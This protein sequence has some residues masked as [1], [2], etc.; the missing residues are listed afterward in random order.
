MKPKKR[1]NGGFA[2]LVSLVGVFTG[3]VS[4]LFCIQHIQRLGCGCILPLMGTLLWYLERVRGWQC[5][6]KG[7]AW[8][9]IRQTSH[10]VC[11]TSTKPPR[12]FTFKTLNLLGSFF[13]SISY[14]SYTK[15][16]VFPVLPVAHPACY[17]LGK[18][19]YVT[20]PTDCD[21]SCELYIMYHD[22]K[23]MCAA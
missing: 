23:E 6:S 5:K 12:A 17:L 2:T 1:Q 9:R 8:L 19:L 20:Y 18:M 14:S 10:F 4:V 7:L 22:E 3:L 15:Y 11:H 13:P 21:T 16:S